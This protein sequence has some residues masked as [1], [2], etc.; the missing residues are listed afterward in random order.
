VKQ[1][2][3]FDKAYNPVTVSL[4]DP[5]RI[6]MV[7][8]NPAG[9]I[10]ELQFRIWFEF[11]LIFQ[12]IKHFKHNLEKSRSFFPCLVSQYKVRWKFLHA[13]RVI[14]GKF[15]TYQHCSLFKI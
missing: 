14:Y 4:F 13:I 3:E 7:S 11:G 9:L 10:H 5:L 2:M 1:S 15:S 6:V 12:D 8:Q